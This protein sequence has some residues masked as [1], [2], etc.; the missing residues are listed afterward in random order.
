MTSPWAPGGVRARSGNRLKAAWLRRQRARYARDLGSNYDRL[1]SLTQG[2][3][4]AVA[5]SLLNLR[6]LS[7]S[8][9]ANPQEM[10]RVLTACREVLKQL[11]PE[12]PS[13]DA[14]VSPD[15]FVALMRQARLELYGAG[16]A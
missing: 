11:K 6:R 9:G 4:D 2:A 1:D 3:I 15:E 14:A 5:L 13:A 8:D 12:A 16:N 7:L 10:V